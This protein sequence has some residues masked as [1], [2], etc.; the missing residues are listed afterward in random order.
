L[1]AT[2][3]FSLDYDDVEAI[4][5]A[6]GGLHSLPIDL[7]AILLT[8]GPDTKGQSSKRVDIP[9]EDTF[10]SGI[11]PYYWYINLQVCKMEWSLRRE[12]SSWDPSS[13]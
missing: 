9:I 1:S 2:E 7:G 13:T 8:L 12:I 3:H 10:A 4:D 5:L 11:S 6:N